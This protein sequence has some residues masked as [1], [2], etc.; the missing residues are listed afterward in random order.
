MTLAEITSHLFPLSEKAL[1]KMEDSVE[2][3]RFPKGHI[4]F[5]QGKT[6]SDVYFL[7]SG[8][9]RAFSEFE[10]NESTF[11]FGFEG[12]VV[13]SMKSYVHELPGY[14]TIELLEDSSFYQ[15]SA[16]NLQQLFQEDLS[17]ANW[18]RKLAES[19]LVKAE[20]RLISRQFLSAS[21]RYIELIKN[22]PQLLHRVALTHIASY[23]GITPVSL[24][25]I[26]SKIK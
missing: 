19:E 26:R 5:R 14:E 23:L 2:L 22:N 6:E 13:I 25:R 1:K 21:Q 15:I 12:S 4:L 11:W 20:E 18:G 9:V 16:S 17:I 3:Q 24:S 10:E 7:K 8:I